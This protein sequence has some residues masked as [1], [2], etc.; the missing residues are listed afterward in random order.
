MAISRRP[1]EKEDDTVK[2]ESHDGAH[3]DDEPAAK[4]L[5]QSTEV[6]IE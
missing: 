2:A 6:K 5:K 3:D 1:G 4:R